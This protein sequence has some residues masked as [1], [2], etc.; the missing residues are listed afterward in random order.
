METVKAL[1]LGAVFFG[2][3]GFMA[4]AIASSA[5]EWIRGK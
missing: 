3:L 1:Y 4:Y 5:I 2:T